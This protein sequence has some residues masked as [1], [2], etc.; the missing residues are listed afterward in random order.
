MGSSGTKA[1]ANI[2]NIKSK[3]ILQKILNN[4]E[5]KRK[6]NLIRF[7]KDIKKRLDINIYDYKEYSEIEIEIKLVNNKFGKFIN[8]KKEDEKYYHIYFDNNKK[9]KNSHYI[10]KD[11]KIE[12]I[13]IIIDYKIKSFKNLFLNVGA[14][15][16][17][18]LK[19]FIGIILII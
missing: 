15:N 5:T 11:E 12:N 13:K 3:Y 9:E 16:L 18:I 17:S 6:L 14:L 4:L 2:E 7:N 8:I 1:K 19:N 10:N